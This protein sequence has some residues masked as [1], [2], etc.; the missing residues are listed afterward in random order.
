MPTITLDKKD[1]MKLVGK[2]IPD[3][4]LK[5][6]ISML[7]T[8]LEKVDDSEITVEVFPNRPDLLSEEGFARAL[9][10]FIGVK[11]GLRKYDVKKSLFKVNVDSS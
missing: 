9:S 11:T 2:E 5:N 8:D 10:S 4:K 6:R 3:E 1:V 7:G